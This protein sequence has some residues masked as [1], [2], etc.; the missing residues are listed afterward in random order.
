MTIV[1]LVMDITP[2]LRTTESSAQEQNIRTAPDLTRTPGASG[3][4]Y[5][6]SSTQFAA[7]KMS[8]T[9]LSASMVSS[10]RSE[11]ASASATAPRLMSET[12]GETPTT[13]ISAVAP[14]SSTQQDAINR[15]PRACEACRT[16]KVRCEPDALDAGGPCKRCAKTRRECVVTAPTRKR[17]KKTDSRV[18][19]LEKKIDML[20][21][22]LG[23]GQGSYNKGD[24]SGHSPEAASG[25][26]RRWLGPV[27]SA[28]GSAPTHDPGPVGSPAMGMKR[29]LNESIQDEETRSDTEPLRPTSFLW[30]GGGSSSGT[31]LATSAVD[32]IDRGLVPLNTAVETFD[33]YVNEMAPHLPVVV[34]PPGTQMADIRRTKPILFHSIIATSIGTIQPE[35]QDTL[36][37]EFYKIIADRVVVRGDKSLELVQAILVAST[38]YLPPE[39][40]EQLK[41]YQL[42]HMAVTLA[43]DIGMG[44]RTM[45][46]KKP[47][48]VKDLLGKKSPTVDLDAPET[49]R[50]WIGCY[51]L[52]V[53]YVFTYLMSFAIKVFGL[54]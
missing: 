18:A 10:S 34:F 2:N 47:F 19:E 35:I 8:P 31:E 44:R 41:F 49:R 30:R 50:L 40:F 54:C 53:Q 13:T 32:V 38:W 15:P 37:D 7:R 51:Y 9:P 14:G 23:S 46:N 29:K 20:T 43:M 1:S 21:A 33:V 16:L 27:Q 26:G 22:S 45:M 4:G 52:S 48:S 6:I 12:D 3:V 24:G 17:Q 39:R 25:P 5:H 28:N 36:M 11:P 42:V